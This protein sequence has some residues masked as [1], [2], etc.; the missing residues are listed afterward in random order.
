LGA[1]ERSA[2]DRRRFPLKA[3]G[4]GSV[5]RIRV[6]PLAPML[7]AGARLRLVDT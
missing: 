6:A 1:V 3:A 7:L 5:G 2:V 4:L